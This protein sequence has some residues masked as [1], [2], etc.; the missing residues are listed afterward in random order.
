MV[1]PERI[2]D[3]KDLFSSTNDAEDV[4]KLKWL[5]GYFDIKGTCSLSAS[6]SRIE[7]LNSNPKVAMLAY[8]LFKR[9]NITSTI[10]ERSQPSKSSKKKRWDIFVNTQKDIIKTAELLKDYVFGKREQ[11][12]TFSRGTNRDSVNQMKYLNSTNHILIADNQKLFLDLGFEKRDI[13]PKS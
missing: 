3:N 1:D 2:K 7:I 8:S 11:L 6:G 5:G 9:N 4:P 10:S 13:L 12:E